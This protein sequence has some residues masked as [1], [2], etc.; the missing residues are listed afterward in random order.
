MVNPQSRRAVKGQ[1]NGRTNHRRITITPLFALRSRNMLGRD[2]CW[3][4]NVDGSIRGPVA[5]AAPRARFVKPLCRFGPNPV[6]GRDHC[7][8]NR[9]ART[10][11]LALGL[12]LDGSVGFSEDAGYEV[13]LGDPNIG[14]RLCFGDVL[15]SPVR[16]INRPEKSALTHYSSLAA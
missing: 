7:S 2:P 11:H 10:T 15:T 14:Q 5:G 8:W 9:L 6:A 16:D 3:A 4:Q 12:N 13:N 1:I